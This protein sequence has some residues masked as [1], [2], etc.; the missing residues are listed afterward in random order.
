MKK[1]RII[2]CTDRYGSNWYCVQKKSIF[3]WWY[4]VVNLFSTYDTDWYDSTCDTG[5]YDSLEEAKALF[6][7]KTTPKKIRVVKT[8]E[9]Q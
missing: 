9:N 7:L 5:W 8:T 2:E 3:G 4:N 1:Y 6:K